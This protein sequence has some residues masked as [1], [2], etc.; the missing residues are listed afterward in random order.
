MI[1][2]DH[3][4]PPA[5]LPAAT[6]IVNPLREGCT[7]PFKALAGVGVTFKLIQGLL[8]GRGGIERAREYEIAVRMMQTADENASRAANLASLS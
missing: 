6:A 4:E 1:V 5:V 3:H 8:R 2:T 7:Y